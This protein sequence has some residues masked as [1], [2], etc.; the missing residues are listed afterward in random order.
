LGADLIVKPIRAVVINSVFLV[1]GGDV[2][3][4]IEP[5]T[6]EVGDPF[7]NRNRRTTRPTYKRV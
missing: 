7:T 6:N 2:K 1:V 3:L 4:R 5:T